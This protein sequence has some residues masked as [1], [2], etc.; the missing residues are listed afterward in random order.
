MGRNILE[1]RFLFA[2]QCHYFYIIDQICIYGS[3]FIQN[4]NHSFSLPSVSPI[5]GFYQL[6][7]F[8]GVS[9]DPT[10]AFID[11]IILCSIQY[12]YMYLHYCLLF[13]P[14]SLF[15]LQFL[16]LTSYILIFNLFNFNAIDFSS[17]LINF[18]F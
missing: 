18:D 10:F 17:Y 4:I 1:H 5:L 9:K 6:Y 3:I 16:E 8:I 15:S 7:H 13:F 12:F 14:F 2:L 11:S